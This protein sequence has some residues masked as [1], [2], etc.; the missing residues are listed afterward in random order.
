MTIETAETTETR[1]AKYLIDHN[2]S[3]SDM[4]ESEIESVIELK[5]EW[6]TRDFLYEKE[7]KEKAEA[8]SQIVEIH[9]TQAEKY[10]QALNELTKNALEAYKNTLEKVQNEQEK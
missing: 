2:I 5:A 4:T 7:Q 10:E 8:L 6:K 3:F 9:K 1:S